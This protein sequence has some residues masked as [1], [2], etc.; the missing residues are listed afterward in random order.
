MVVISVSVTTWAGC[1]IKGFRF[2]LS[3]QGFCLFLTG[4]KGFDSGPHFSPYLQPPAF[5]K[6]NQLIREGFMYFG[7][8]KVTLHME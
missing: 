5:F 6:E 1:S 2:L 8:E 7:K 3:G 4:K